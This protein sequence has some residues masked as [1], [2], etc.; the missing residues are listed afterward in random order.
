MPRLFKTWRLECRIGGQL[1]KRVWT[2][3][4]ASRDRR[5]STQARHKHKQRLFLRQVSHRIRCN[6]AMIRMSLI[7]LSRRNMELSVYP[8]WKT[9]MASMAWFV[10]RQTSK[11]SAKPQLK[12]EIKRLFCL[13]IRIAPV[14]SLEKVAIKVSRAKDVRLREKSYHQPPWIQISHPK[15][16]SITQILPIMANTRLR[17]TS[18]H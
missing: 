7:W 6:L 3:R 2:F 12:L 15:G 11:M 16:S 14:T 8:P 4:R 17:W 5:V 9:L 10:K 1:R 13:L 18:S